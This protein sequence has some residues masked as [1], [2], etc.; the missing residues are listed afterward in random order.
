ME[1]GSPPFPL[2]IADWNVLQQF[3]RP[4]IQDLIELDITLQPVYRFVT[5]L[6]FIPQIDG[7][8]E[9]AC[10]PRLV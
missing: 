3:H 5:S 2:K 10:R 4:L 7:T 6:S 1:R 8:F 9:P